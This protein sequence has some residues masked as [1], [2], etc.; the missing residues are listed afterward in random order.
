MAKRSTIGASPL[1]ALIPPPAA[2]SA[3]A[4]AAEE[5]R[6]A[7]SPRQ[8]KERLTIHLTVDLIE[9]VKNAVYWTPGLTL[10]GLAEEALAR[11]VD[12][13]EA[14]NKARFR[15]RREELK[16]GRPLK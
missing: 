3:P 5:A 16:G 4:P 12:E 8:A 1:D 2:S 14:D 13:M 10:A 6:P 9:R 11:A 7:R 15:P